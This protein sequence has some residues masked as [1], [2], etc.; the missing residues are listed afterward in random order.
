MKSS[1]HIVRLAALTAMTCFT[2]AHAEEAS[3]SLAPKAEQPKLEEPAAAPKTELQSGSRGACRANWSAKKYKPY[4]KVQSEVK[5]RHG[6]VRILRVALCGEGPGAYFQ[7]VIIS[8][9]G[10]VSRVQIAALN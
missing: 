4:D 5:R 3:R 7:I 2:P 9:T 8:G 1:M 10:S 6:D